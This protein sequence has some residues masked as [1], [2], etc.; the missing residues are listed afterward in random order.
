MTSPWCAMAGHE[1][2]GESLILDAQRLALDREVE[3]LIITPQPRQDVYN[4][5]LVHQR[6]VQTDRDIDH[7]HE[8]E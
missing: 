2:G 1:E 3:T 7:S 6:G 8:D 5:S 4:A